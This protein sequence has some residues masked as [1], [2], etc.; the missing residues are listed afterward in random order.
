MLWSNRP[1]AANRHAHRRRAPVQG[2]ILH[3]PFGGTLRLGV[4]EAVVEQVKVPAGRAPGGPSEELGAQRLSCAR[5]AESCLAGIRPVKTHNQKSVRL[6]LNA[7][8]VVKSELASV[9]RKVNCGK[10]AV[11]RYGECLASTLTYVRA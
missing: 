8:A 9:P 3:H 1:D 7:R 5:H 10:E 4:A 6:P 2:N 11:E